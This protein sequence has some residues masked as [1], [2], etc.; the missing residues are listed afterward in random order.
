MDIDFHR[1]IMFATI[2]HRGQ[3]R[4]GTDLPYIIH[5]MDVAMRLMQAG[6]K[7]TAVLQAAVLHDVIEDTPDTHKD[8]V[9]SFG[10]EV[11]GI[12]LEVTDDDT[13]TKR[14]QR[15]AGIARARNLSHG[16]K[17][18]KLADMASNVSS[19]DLKRPAKWSNSL[20]KAYIK[21]CCQVADGCRFR[22]K[23]DSGPH[24]TRSPWLILSERFDRE[25]ELALDRID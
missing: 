13:L 9:N 18:V 7:D 20:K 19:T 12:V 8:L 3:L 15:E 5:P 17:L 23:V 10:E 14:Q 25:V 11:A 16:A 6:V 24:E 22:G 4:S 21:T 1:S 2:A